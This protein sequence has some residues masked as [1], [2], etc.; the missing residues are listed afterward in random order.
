MLVSYLINPLFILS[1]WSL[2]L[3]LSRS[4]S[5]ITPDACSLPYRLLILSSIC[6][7]SFALSLFRPLSLSPPLSLSL[8]QHQVCPLSYW[9]Y[10]KLFSLL[11]SCSLSHSLSFSLRHHRCS[12][13]ARSINYSLVYILSLLRPLSL[14][15]PLSLFLFDNTRCLFL[16]LLI[17]PKLFSLLY[18]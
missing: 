15:H 5:L 8:R 9:S 12:S 4:F 11:Y 2:S 17:L 18:S 10:Q 16:V 1:I 3:S 14:S 13:V 6:S 7:L